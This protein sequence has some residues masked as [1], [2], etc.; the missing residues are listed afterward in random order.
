LNDFQLIME[1]E[2][3]N[4]EV[5]ADL[6]TAR[7]HVEKAGGHKGFKKITIEEEDDD[8]NNEEEVL[9]IKILT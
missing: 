1:K 8:S 9:L 2:P 7:M 5:N 4:A 3:N 6:K